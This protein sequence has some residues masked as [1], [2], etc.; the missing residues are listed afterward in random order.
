MVSHL[1]VLTLAEGLEVLR[2]MERDVQLATGGEDALLPD[3]DTVAQ[4]SMALIAEVVEVADELQWKR[5]KRNTP[6]DPHSAGVEMS[7]M[8]AFLGLFL[9][10]LDHYGISM[11]TLA[12]SFADKCQVNTARLRGEVPGYGLRPQAPVEQP[13][14]AAEEWVYAPVTEE[15]DELLE[16]IP[17]GDHS[18]T[19]AYLRW[20][21]SLS[22]KERMKEDRSI[23]E[24]TSED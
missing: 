6:P 16:T 15:E 11:A 9:N 12:Q 14:V 7:D 17:S 20:Y 8:L 18:R 24:Y 21:D 10:W 2:C 13:T 4:F 23:A 3:R 1:Q 5:W 22:R 19:L